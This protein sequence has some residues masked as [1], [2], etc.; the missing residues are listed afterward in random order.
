MHDASSGIAKRSTG[1]STG[2]P[3]TGQ[4]LETVD[5]SVGP[6]GKVILESNP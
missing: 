5:E 1:V 3:P 6:V 4:A 2:H